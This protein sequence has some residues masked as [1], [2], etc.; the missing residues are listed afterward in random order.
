MDAVMVQDFL[1]ATIRIAMPLMLAALG[2][3]LSERAGTFAVALEGQMLC[4]ALAGVVG[5]HF[6]GNLGFGLLAAAAGGALFGLVVAIATVRFDTEHMVTGIAANILALGLTSY[7]LRAAVGGGQAPVLRVP[8]LQP[9]PVPYL[10]DV[11][12]V[13]PLLFQQPPLTYLAL[14]LLVSV[15]LFLFR[16]R[17]GLTLRAVGENPL[18]A[19]AA[20]AQPARVRMAAIL[21]GAVLAGLGGAVLTLQ[22]VGTFTDGMTHG[23]G[24]L[25][26]AAIIVGR[27]MPIGT[28]AGCL[29]FGAAE[30]LQI[31]V[32]TLS[33]PV[34]SYVIQMAPYILALAVLAGLQR[35]S[36]LPAAIG[37]PLRI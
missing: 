7:L 2:G 17:A 33:L 12:F 34:S 23:R 37:Q 3:I 26:L 18:A 32:Q 21:G 24:Y 9:W 19:Y 6:A 14:A 16:T 1:S 5:T 28:L 36:R 20:G 4:G 31:R 27:W 15:H 29:L 10:A 30:A 35:S 22:Q 13:G 11:P 8:L 25:A